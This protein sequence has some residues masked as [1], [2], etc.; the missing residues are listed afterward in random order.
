MPLSTEMEQMVEAVLGGSPLAGRVKALLEKHSKD[1]LAAFNKKAFWVSDDAYIWAEMLA[2]GATRILEH[3]LFSYVTL[4]S[5]SA[6][7]Y[8]F[9]SI[10]GE[11]S[12]NTNLSNFSG[13]KV[14]ESE[15][16][17][18]RA[19]CIELDPTLSQADKRALLRFAQ[20]SV[21]VSNVPYLDRIPI[22]RFPAGAGLDGELVN[23][24][25]GADAIYKFRRWMRWGPAETY[26]VKVKTTH[27]SGTVPTGT[28]NWMKVSLL[29]WKAQF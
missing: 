16:H 14:P 6:K 29:G 9:F 19:M 11:A 18:F 4:D 2:R 13:P 15:M 23:G 25:V 8:T 21:N 5:T 17:A 28:S 20:V 7:E 27:T 26:N 12:G 1:T 24:G 10:D 3:E 22:S